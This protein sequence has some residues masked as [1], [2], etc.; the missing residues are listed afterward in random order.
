MKHESPNAR[1]TELGDGCVQLR[2]RAPPGVEL[3]D[4]RGR[5][6]LVRLSRGAVHGLD[7]Q[8]A[9]LFVVAREDHSVSLLHRVEE[10]PPPVQTWGGETLSTLGDH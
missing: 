8:D 9:V 1:R 3:L 5:D 4:L 6:G 2:R 10:G 7:P